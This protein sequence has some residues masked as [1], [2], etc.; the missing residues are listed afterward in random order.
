MT[1]LLLDRPTE[2]WWSTRRSRG[3]LV[4]ALL[5]FLVLGPL[6]TAVG[7]EEP[8][9]SAWIVVPLAIAI[10]ALQLRHSF[11]AARGV[12]PRG[13]ADHA[14]GLGLARVRAPDLVPMGLGE[15]TMRCSSPRSPCFCAAG[16]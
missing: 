4:A 9:R 14:P 7:L 16:S 8:P 5:P 2:M 11:A 3:L 12:L 15:Y 10:G 6:I 1:G 13:L